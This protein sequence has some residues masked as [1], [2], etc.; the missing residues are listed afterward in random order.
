MIKI[1]T[2]PPGFSPDSLRVTSIDDAGPHM[3]EH[4]HIGTFVALLKSAR[5]SGSTP[6]K[7]TKHAASFASLVINFRSM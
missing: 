1:A 7:C 3:E 2:W 6:R 5:T 4:T